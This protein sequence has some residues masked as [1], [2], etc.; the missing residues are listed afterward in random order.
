[1]YVGAV[2][3]RV[4][5]GARRAAAAVATA[6]LLGA[7]TA[8]GA[9]PSG[10]ADA[11]SLVA[12]PSAC[13]Q[14]EAVWAE[15]GTLVPRERFEAR[16]RAAAGVTPPVEILDLGGSFR[17]IAAGRVR[18]YKDEAR[19]CANRARIAAL[20]VALAIDPAD[21]LPEPPPAPRPPP[22]PAP[23]PTPTPAPVAVE[24]AV[25][26]APLPRPAVRLDLGAA[27]D[28]GLAAN[29]TVT[30]GGVAVVIAAGRGRLAGVFGA[31]ALAPVDTSVGGVRLRQWRVPLYAGVRGQLDG[32]RLEPYADVGLGAALLSE[33][34]LDLAAPQSQTAVELGVAASLGARLPMRLAP[35]A[36]LQ[37]ELVPSPPAIF[38]LPQG[39]VGHT[40]TLWLGLCAGLSLGLL[41]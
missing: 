34:A 25:E 37:L 4:H 31:V 30:Q 3:D 11:S 38:A 12:G 15:L 2:R 14:P 16:L 32:K 20:F 33:R 10:P 41:R 9:E 18:T 24:A 8:A 28:T 6:A 5:R 36:A 26:A 23:P 35:F 1:L 22:P 27:V 19:D 40:P 17:V 39:V 21:I 29:A 13:P 7:A